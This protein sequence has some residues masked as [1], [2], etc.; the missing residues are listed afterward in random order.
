M[1]DAKQ[2]TQ[3]VLAALSH[4]ET[5]R[6]PIGE[7]FWTNFIRRCRAE[8]ERAGAR[9][10][11]ANPQAFEQRCM[12]RPDDDESVT[13]REPAPKARPATLRQVCD[14]LDPG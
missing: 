11:R 7:F 12:V 4:Q 8:L 9:P 14:G 2:K 5:D 1:D 6:V 3:R 10:D 13:G